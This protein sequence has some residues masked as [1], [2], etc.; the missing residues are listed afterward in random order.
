MKLMKTILDLNPWI[1]LV[2]AGIFEIGFTSFM[3]LSQGFEKWTFNIFFAVCA[4][5]SFAF[6]NLSTRGISLGTA[7]AVWT[8]IGAFGTAIIGVILFQDPTSLWRTVF[9]TTLIGSIIGLKFFS[10]S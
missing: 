10:P 3:K 1:F 6:L 7:Y 4:I 8:G 5:L 9:L 2:T